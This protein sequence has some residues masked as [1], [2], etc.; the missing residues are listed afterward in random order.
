MA[1]GRERFALDLWASP[2]RDHPGRFVRCLLHPV[3][4][5]PIGSRDLVRSILAELGRI[6][7]KYVLLLDPYHGSDRK[8]PI[9]KANPTTI[10]TVP[11]SPERPA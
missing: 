3:G 9:E 4:P 8:S 11:Y 5:R 1:A 2:S 6:A 7:A 10:G